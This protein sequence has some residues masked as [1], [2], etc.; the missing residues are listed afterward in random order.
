MWCMLVSMKC[1][2]GWN[3][4]YLIFVGVCFFTCEMLNESVLHVHIST[5]N[6]W[7][8]EPILSSNIILQQ[9]SAWKSKSTCSQWLCHCSLCLLFWCTGMS[10]YHSC[11][12][13]ICIV[14]PKIHH[15]WPWTGQGHISP[16]ETGQVQGIG[17]GQVTSPSQGPHRPFAYTILSL[18]GLLCMA[19]DGGRQLEYLESLRITVKSVHRYCNNNRMCISTCVLFSE[20]WCQTMYFTRSGWRWWHPP[21]ST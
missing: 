14:H 12:V 19:L 17:P 18:I 2:H 6:F 3:F 9:L 13:E 11:K 16:A 4:I 10:Q 8:R 20:S 5:N 7:K 1:N 15:L 21:Y